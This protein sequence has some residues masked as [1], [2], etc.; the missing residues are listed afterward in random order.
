MHDDVDSA[1]TIPDS[2]SNQGATCGSGHIC[3]DELVSICD[4]LWTRP[5]CGDDRR[6]C[7]PKCRNDSLADTLG[8]AR[9]ERAFSF[10]FQVVV[11]Q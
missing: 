1:E 10:E 6:T 9:H 11:H 2:I 5:R 8:A 3:R 7:F 4:I